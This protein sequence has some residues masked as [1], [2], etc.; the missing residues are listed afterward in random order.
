MPDRPPQN[1]RIAREPAYL[2][3]FRVVAGAGIEPETRGFSVLHFY[4]G[5]LTLW[6][7]CGQFSHEEIEDRRPTCRR[8]CDTEFEWQ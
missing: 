2:L 5:E 7:I 6:T 8:W 1:H 4:S 3:G